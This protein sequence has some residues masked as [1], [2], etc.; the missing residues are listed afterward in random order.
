M[1]KFGYNLH[2]ENNNPVNIKEDF[3]NNLHSSIGENKI[4]INDLVNLNLKKKKNI[5]NEK[6]KLINIVKQKM[7]KKLNS[8]KYDD[9][10]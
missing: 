10:N 1:N 6:N 5:D 2:N 7:I 3:N 4:S 8:N 9:D